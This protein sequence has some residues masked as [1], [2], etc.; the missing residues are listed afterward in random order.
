[1][2]R[3]LLKGEG[4]EKVEGRIRRAI[5]SPVNF[6]ELKEI[7]NSHVYNRRWERKKEIRKGVKH[8]DFVLLIV[9]SCL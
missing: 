7:I 5:S 9:L 8:T 3:T 1:M 2:V 4:K 6:W